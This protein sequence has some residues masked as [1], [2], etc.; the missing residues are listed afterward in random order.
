MSIKGQRDALM[1]TF[2]FQVRQGGDQRD[3]VGEDNA[4]MGTFGDGANLSSDNIIRH[5][6]PEQYC[7]CSKNAPQLQDPKCRHRNLGQ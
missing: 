7:R 5:S 3:D 1:V 2:R 4:R 6:P